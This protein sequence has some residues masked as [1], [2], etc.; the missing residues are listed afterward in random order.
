[1]K[2]ASAHT[3]VVVALAAI[4]ALAAGCGPVVGVKAT[5]RTDDLTR[6][7]RQ[8]LGERGGVAPRAVLMPIEPVGAPMGVEELTALA[9]QYEELEERLAELR[10]K[11]PAVR[12]WETISLHNRGVA[13]WRLGERE[14]AARLLGL[15]L[16]HARRYWLWSLQWQ[17]ELT[18]ARAVPEQRDAS[19]AAAADLIMGHPPLTPL[20]YDLEE[21]ERLNALYGALIHSTL[22]QEPERA[23]GYALEWEAVVLARAVPPGKLSLPSGEMA[24]RVAALEEARAALARE[25]AR[26]C[27]L[28]VEQAVGPVEGSSAWERLVAVRDDVRTASPAGGLFVPAPADVVALREDLR[29]GSLMLLFAPLDGRSVAGFALGPEVFAARRLSLPAAPEELTDRPNDAAGALLEPFATEIEAARRVY[30]SPSAALSGLSW[31]RFPVGGVPLG[32][33]LPVVFLGGA[34][35]WLW[36][37]QQRHY[38]RQSLLI[39]AGGE[40]EGGPLASAMAGIPGTRILDI[41]QSGK[42]DLAEAMAFTDTVWLGNPVSLL[43]GAAGDAYV[44]FPG[45]PGRLAGVSLGELCTYS[46]RAGAVALAGLPRESFDAR[47]FLALRVLTRCLV[48]AGAPTVAY[49]VDGADRVEFWRPF[50]EGLR[51]G[52]AAD[53]YHSS[54]SELGRDA[55]GIFRLYGFAGLS[56][57][58]YAEFSRLDF[59]DTLRTARAELSAGRFE[60]AAAGFLDLWHMAQALSFGSEPEKALILANIQQMLGECWRSLR[61]YD[62]AAEHQRLR[63]EHL[64]ESGRASAPDMAKEQQS[65]GALLTMDEQFEGAAAAYERSVELLRE[66]GAPEQIAAVQG[67]RGKSLDR[68]ADYR[69]ALGAFRAALAVYERLQQ[70]A[71][72]ALQHQRIGAVYLK[73]LNEPLR[74]EEQFAR[75]RD[76]YER[77]GDAEGMLESML[78]VGLCRRRMGDFPR[79]LELFEQVRRQAEERDLPATVARAL[80]ELG[81]TRWFRGEYQQALELVSQSNALARELDIPFRLNVNYQLLALIYWELNQYGRAHESLDVAVEQARRAEMPLEVAGAYNNRGI[82]YRRQGEYEQA[83]EWFRE[84]LSIDTRLRSR[85][86]QGYDHR[87]I[88]M[89]LHRMGRCAEASGHLERA[90]AMAREIGD[91]VNMAKSLLALGDLRLDQERPDEAE[92]LLQEALGEAREVFLPEV[93]W[94]AL[95]GLGRLRRERGDNEAAWEALRQAVEVVETM[96]AGLKIEEFR[97]GYVANKMALYED[98]V[99]L[100]LDMDRPE[101]AFHYSE[102]SRSR[103]FMDV[104]AGRDI[105][106]KTDEERELF[107]RRKELA[108][109][110]RS[111]REAVAREADADR[112]EEL[113]AQLDG[114]ERQYADLLLEI[115]VSHPQL[116]GFVAVEAVTAEELADFVPE[117]VTLLVYYVLDDQIAIWV[118]DGEKLTA[119]Q[120]A[121]GRDALAERIRRYRMMVQN[122]ELLAEVRQDS[123]QL[124]ELLLAPVADL[125]DDADTTCIVPHSSLHYLSF[126]SLYDGRAFLVER[127]PLFYSP[128]V[129]VLRRTLS[130][131][132]PGDRARVRVLAVGNPDV[133]DPAYELPFTEREVVSIGRTFQQ[134]DSLTGPEATEERVRAEMGRYEVVHIG[135]H[136]ILDSGNPL[137]SSLVLAPGEQDG[138]LHLYEVTGLDLNAQLVALSAC[139]SGVGALQSADELVSLSRAFAYA[140]A[141]S[142]LSTLWR[143]DD[144]STALVS[145][146]FYRQYLERGA[147]ESL[148]AAQLQVMNDGRHYHPT[149]WAGVVLSGDYR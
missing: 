3:A 82:I 39:C 63:I 45:A 104:V 92:E 43:P 59:N 37:F 58:Q 115:R 106:L 6:L 128:S 4:L 33:K 93:E 11:T 5:I 78:D 124:H 149:Y 41:R 135:A 103:K 1:M 77:A 145:K 21:E 66:E 35:D 110:L 52:P 113:A 94:R 121:V 79:A 136:G 8:V 95:R 53:A 123:R 118:W 17:V 32:R 38:G 129:S 29:A 68:A 119:R 81:N 36:A 87:N 31:Q 146:H 127:L 137:F 108:H 70:P 107:E 50:L 131:E 88:G 23:L 84:A 72:V 73:R 140:G 28:S 7:E 51:E 120:V 97:S 117:D 14:E 76:A 49:A 54:V 138:F 102:R 24:G 67:E 18:R 132:P 86:G 26:R 64:D 148:R 19:L 71:G 16:R 147:A 61:H 90:V 80:A 46:T 85:W 10:P 20:D 112:R 57:E 98:A 91:R 47:H 89:T 56:E 100:L 60:D 142:I 116:G 75:A 144:V 139:Q 141:R 34:S 2:H 111:L 15:A 27:A 42:R 30:L 62:L 125:I 109:R 122:R 48:T 65:L 134:V 114:L 101:E 25:R 22:D 130:G 40:G 143:V 133:G 126:A 69:A 9:T 12:A 99:A 74:A 55:R 105:E 13:R 83:L 96:G 44:A